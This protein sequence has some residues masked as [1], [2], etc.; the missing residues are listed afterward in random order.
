MVDHDCHKRRIVKDIVYSLEVHRYY[1]RL[2]PIQVYL[3]LVVFFYINLF[4]SSRGITI[5]AYLSILLS[6]IIQW[7]IVQV[8]LFKFK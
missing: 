6:I 1:L 5:I 7:L 4:N 2:Y 8:A 3:L